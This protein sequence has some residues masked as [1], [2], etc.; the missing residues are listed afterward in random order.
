MRQLFQLLRYSTFRGTCLPYIKKIFFSS[1]RW[2]LNRLLRYS[3]YGRDK[4]PISQEDFSL[5]HEDDELHDYFGTQTGQVPHFPKRT[6]SSTRRTNYS[7]TPVLDPQMGNTPYP[8]KILFVHE[9]IIDRLLKYSIHGWD[10]FPISNKDSV[11]R[12]VTILPL[13]RT[14][15]QEQNN[16]LLQYS[17]NLHNFYKGTTRLRD[18]K[19]IDYHGTRRN[20]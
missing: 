1:M 8:L 18:D 17:N 15:L 9:T 12:E 4:L 2:Q 7:T 16:W 20:K 3:I 5:I 10:K 6:S 19:K 13:L 11:I 14:R